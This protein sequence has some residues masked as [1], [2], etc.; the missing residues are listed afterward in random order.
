[1]LCQC[2]VSCEQCTPDYYYGECSDYHRDCY[3]WSRGGQ[4]T[5]NKWML[6][7]CRRSCNSCIDP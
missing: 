7:N 6:E 1:M 4:C 2:R 5:R 3:K